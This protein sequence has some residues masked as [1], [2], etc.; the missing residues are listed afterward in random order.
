MNFA[1]NCVQPVLKMKAL[2]QG[3]K[4]RLARAAFSTDLE[5]DA[6]VNC[7][8]TYFDYF[9]KNNRATAALP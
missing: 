5:F 8:A 2:L 7:F 9:E 4:L 3:S 6:V 1:L